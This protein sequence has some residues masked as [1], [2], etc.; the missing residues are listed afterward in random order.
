M[1][2]LNGR[3]STRVR[4]TSRSYN[5]SW[6]SRRRWTGSARWNE[7]I[8]VLTTTVGDDL[9]EAPDFHTEMEARLKMNW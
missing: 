7:T 8:D 4:L 3:T 9:R 6:T 1:S 5:D 2:G